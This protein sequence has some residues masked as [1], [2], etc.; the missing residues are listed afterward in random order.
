MREER[1]KVVDS[2]TRSFVKFGVSKK[3]VALALEAAES[4]QAAIVAKR[5]DAGSVAMETLRTH[6][7]SGIVLVGRPYNIYDRRINLDVPAKL[8]DYYGIDVIPMDFIDVDSVD[9]RDVNAN[10]YWNYGG[11]IIAAAKITKDNSLLNLIYVT[12]FKCGPDSF[13]K[14]FI[15]ESGGKPFLTLQFDG[16]ANDAGI[17]TRCE[18]F[19]ESKGMLRTWSGDNVGSPKRESEAA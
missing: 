16:H 6:N 14:H 1:K 2:L 18:A 15:T 19:L 8:R 3:M 4:A 13:I 7:R 9:I 10:M 12:N 11:K 5:H 17:M